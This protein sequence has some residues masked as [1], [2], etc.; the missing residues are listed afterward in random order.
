[1]QL[2]IHKCT[3]TTTIKETEGK[4]WKKSKEWWYKGQF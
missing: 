4:M 3:L 1:M 2:G